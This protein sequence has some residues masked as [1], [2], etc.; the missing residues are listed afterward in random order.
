MNL[1]S[2]IYAAADFLK[3]ATKQNK[4]PDKIISEVFRNKK[5]FGSKDRKF[6]SEL[7]FS[8]LRN[9]LLYKYI[10]KNLSV[11]NSN[12]ELKIIVINCML[13]SQSDLWFTINIAPL[14]EKLSATEIELYNIINTIV[15]TEDLFTA[16]VENNFIGKILLLIQ[17]L[18]DNADNSLETF[19]TMYSLPIW[20]IDQLSPVINKKQFAYNSLLPA[21]TFI[22]INN[23]LGSKNNVFSYFS[24]NNIAI[25][26]GNISHSAYKFYNRIK[27]DDNE[28]FKSGLYEIQD[29]GSQLISI[30]LSPTQNSKILDACAGA[31]GKSLHLADITNDKAEIIASDTEY[32]RLKEIT[33]RAYRC[34]F[35][36]IQAKLIKKQDHASLLELYNYKNFDYVLVDAPCSGMGTIRRDPSRKYK[37]SPKLVTRLAEAQYRILSQYAQFVKNGGILVYSTCSVLEEEND[38]VIERFL[39]DNKNFEPDDLFE[40]F[41]EHN[42]EIPHL[43]KGDYKVTLGFDRYECDGFFMAR[44]RKV[45]HH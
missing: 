36:S 25:Q 9:L 18:L 44:L 13:S 4:A 29:E 16:N 7:V 35:K 34:G 31:G 5:Y 1:Q 39:Q 41:A 33:K 6:I 21:P 28:L 24:S 37:V 32:G 42:L 19:Q 45:S 12:E 20:I 40:V 10:V 8:S 17:E 2:L 43:N 11:H 27:L 38:K 26:E 15:V 30:A 22:R 23:S 3:M 14:I